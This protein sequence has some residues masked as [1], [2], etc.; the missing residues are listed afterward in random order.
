M[1]RHIKGVF[2]VSFRPPREGYGMNPFRHSLGVKIATSVFV[3]A[4]LVYAAIVAVDVNWFRDNLLVELKN[5]S[6]FSAE[7]LMMAVEEPM[8]KGDDEA[9]RR[10]FESL[11][12]YG[13]VSLYLTDHKGEIT[14]SNRKETLR[15]HIAETIPDGA[16]AGMLRQSLTSPVGRSDL[17]HIAGE[18]YFAEIKTVA[19][20][21]SCHH[22]HGSARSILGAVVMLQNVSEQHERLQQFHFERTIFLLLGLTALLAAVLAYIHRAFITRVALITRKTGE[23]TAGNLDIRFDVGGSDELSRLCHHLNAMVAGRKRAEGSLAD[24]NRG[25]EE[26]VAQRTRALARQAAELEEANKRV[27]ERERLKTV[28]L[29]TVSHE[30]KTPLTAVL[31][32]ARLIARRFSRAVLPQASGRSDDFGR[33]AAQI[34]ANLPVMI[35]EAER[36]S[37]L[38]DKVV[39]LSDLES[40]SAAFDMVPMDLALAARQAVEAVRPAAE[41]KGLALTLDGAD[42]A[43][44][45][46]GDAR[47]LAAALK[48]LLDNAV[49]FTMSGGVTCRVRPTADGAAV[50]VTDTGRGI[51]PADQKAIFQTFRQLGDHLTDKP[52][53]MG[54]GLAIARAVARAHGG[55]VTVQSEPGAGSVFTLSV[56]AVSPNQG[57]GPDAA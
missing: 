54:L 45:V 52:G 2:P 50:D 43:C 55:R 14:Y 20:A 1:K 51:A 5:A 30:F 25:L 42:E 44:P 29:S 21:P 8:R 40:G 3:S 57:P 56:R 41:A 38:V 6:D 10:Q 47:R 7:L 12:P 18:P 35:Q 24:L 19:N 26:Q 46:T 4:I 23:V 39:E 13:H 22:C 28:F 49:A 36:L 27:R 34:A 11:A 53:G 32:F 48:H 37:A 17:L 9:T 33:S 31:G 16:F 15:R